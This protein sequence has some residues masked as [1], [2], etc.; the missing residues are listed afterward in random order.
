MLRCRRLRPCSW[1]VE[2]LTLE[3]SRAAQWIV[4]GWHARPGR[5]TL[6]PDVGVGG[7]RKPGE[8][9]YTESSEQLEVG[10]RLR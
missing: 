7:P 3:I 9:F 4:L 8:P 2:I 1:G 5:P 6:H 10:G